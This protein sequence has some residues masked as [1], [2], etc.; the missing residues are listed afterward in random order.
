M[1]EPGTCPQVSFVEPRFLGESLGSSSDDHPFL[2]RAKWPAFMN[3]VYNA[4]ISSPNWANTV[5]VINYDEWGGFFDHV[6]PPALP[7]RPR[8]LAE[9]TTMASSVSALL[10]S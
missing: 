9:A 3:R 2:G 6:P 4:V 7:F 5:F 1:R 8:T 10:V